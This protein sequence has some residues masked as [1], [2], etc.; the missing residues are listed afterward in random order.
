MSLTPSIPIK[1]SS[2]MI[3]KKDAGQRYI[4]LDIF[5]ILLAL[6]IFMFHSN[7]HLK[8]SYGRIVNALLTH[9]GAVTMTAFF[10]LSGYL[11]GYVHGKSDFSHIKVIKTFYIKRLIAIL[12]SYYFVAILFI[13]FLRKN[14]WLEHMVLFPV[15]AIGYQSSFTS[16]FDYSHNNGT[17]FV[18]CILFCYLLYPL[19][20]IIVK[21]LKQKTKYIVFAVSAFILLYA[22]VVSLFFKIRGIYT[23]PIFR[24]LE[25]FLGVLLTSMEESWPNE[26]ASLRTKLLIACGI[27]WMGCSSLLYYAIKKISFFSD[28]M[29]YSIFFLP[30]W[31]IL[32]LL[33]K[34]INIKRSWIKRIIVFFSSIAY[35]IFLVQFF[36][37]PLQKKIDQIILFPNSLR[38]ICSF[39]I[40]ISF[41]IFVHL[42]I[43]RP[44]QKLIK[45]KVKKYESA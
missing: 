5:R 28:Y 22:P 12:P 13:A 40:C 4:G 6:E 39:V 10:I 26:R 9:F 36:V 45:K 44:I 18:S 42:V 19:M 30:V 14:T 23:V 35:D 21:Q 8:C 31:V 15:E 27:L 34:R 17:W 37:W 1:E 32:I 7:G 38:I 2:D 20:H 29:L 43:E 3:Q 41:A 11:I 33:F 24:A 16:L 25:F